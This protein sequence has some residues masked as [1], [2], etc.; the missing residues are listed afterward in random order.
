MQRTA[1]PVT[2][3]G[4]RPSAALERLLTAQSVR[5]VLLRRMRPAEDVDRRKPAVCADHH[6]RTTSVIQMMRVHYPAR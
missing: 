6:R 5:D 2:T 4:R 1:A 3:S